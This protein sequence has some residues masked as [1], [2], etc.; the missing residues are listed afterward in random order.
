MNLRPD[1]YVYRNVE[2]VKVIDGDTVDVRLSVDIGFSIRAVQ[3]RLRLR[4]SDRDLFDQE[5]YHRRGL[6]ALPSLLYRQAKTG[7]YRRTCRAIP[8]AIRQEEGLSVP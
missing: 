3:D 7:G 8:E 6:L 1:F 4:Q 2:V 5:K